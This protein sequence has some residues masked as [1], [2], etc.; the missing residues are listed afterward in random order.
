MGFTLVDLFVPASIIVLLVSILLVYSRNQEIPLLLLREQSQ[1]VSVINRAKVLS[2]QAFSDPDVPC[3]IGV[4]FQTNGRYFMFKDQAANCA[5]SN[6]VWESGDAIISGEDYLM[7]SKIIFATLPINSVV[8]AP[9]HPLT[10]LNGSLTF[11]EAQIRFQ[12]V[13]EPNFFRT[14]TINNAGQIT[15]Q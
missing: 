15:T 8:F 13:E 3:G 4:Y 12:V 2:I 6:Y 7:D 11:G 5:N 14:I 1:L 10:Y 9:P